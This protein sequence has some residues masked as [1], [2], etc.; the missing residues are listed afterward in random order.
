MAEAAGTSSSEVTEMAP[1]EWGPFFKS[2]RRTMRVYV[3]DLLH[4]IGLSKNE[5]RRWYNFEI[6]YRPVPLAWAQEAAFA[7]GINLDHLY[8]EAGLWPPDLRGLPP[9]LICEL[10]MVLRH[11]KGKLEDDIIAAI[12]DKIGQISLRIRKARIFLED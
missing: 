1:K 7:L 11:E 5:M 9:S 4:G 8:Y 10:L 2:A 12:E 6:G 3:I